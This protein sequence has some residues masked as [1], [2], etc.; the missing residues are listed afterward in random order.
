MQ[1]ARKNA[2]RKISL[3]ASSLYRYRANT[4]LE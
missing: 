4:L 1:L 3:G 2:K